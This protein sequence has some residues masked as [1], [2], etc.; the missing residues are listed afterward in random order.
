MRSFSAARLL[1]ISLLLLALPPLS[2]ACG[3]SFYRAAP[4]LRADGMTFAVKTLADLYDPPAAAIP[5]SENAARSASLQAAALEAMKLPAAGGRARLDAL[6]AQARREAFPSGTLNLLWDFRDLLDSTPEDS[7]ERET[8]INWRL[9]HT[10]ANAI[11]TLQR[12]IALNR[13]NLWRTQAQ[14]MEEARKKRQ[15]A[16]RSEVQNLSAAGAATALPALQPHWRMQVAAVWFRA[17]E[18]TR[19]AYEFESIVRDFPKHPRVETAAFMALRCRIELARDAIGEWPQRDDPRAQ[20][21]ALPVAWDNLNHFAE[22]YGQGRFAADLPGWKG[23]LNQIEGNWPQAFLNYIEQAEHREQPAA[24][25]SGLREA[26]RCLLLLTKNPRSDSGIDRPDFSALAE[27]PQAAMRLI[28]FLL[29]PTATTRFDEWPWSTDSNDAV[30]IG[31][32]QR[33][34]RWR[35]RQDCE[36]WLPEL[37]RI[38]ELKEKSNAAGW[39]PFALAVVAW[40]ACEEGEY[41]RVLTLCRHHED[42][43]RTGDDLRMVRA[44]ALQR[45]GR[46]AEA[47]AAWGELVRDFPESPLCAQATQRLTACL[48]E[49]GNPAAA[50]VTILEAQELERE[51]MKAAGAWSEGFHEYPLFPTGENL[52][53]WADVL[54]VAAPVEALTAAHQ[55]CPSGPVR[56]RLRQVITCRLLARGDFGAARNFMQD[57]WP[58]GDPQNT[59]SSEDADR[60]RPWPLPHDGETWDR[61]FAPVA[62]LLKTAREAAPESAGSAAAWLAAGEAVAGL[63]EQWSLSTV[64]GAGMNSENR[65]TESR[66]RLNARTLGYRAE[67]I[68][69]ELLCQDF[70]HLASDCWK[71]AE[72]A[73]PG[74]PA[75]IRAMGLRNEALRQRAEYTPFAARVADEQDWTTESARLTAALRDF[76]EAGAGLVST[77]AAAVPWQFQDFPWLRGNITPSQAGYEVLSCFE[78]PAVAQEGQGF[79]FPDPAVSALEAFGQKGRD[80]ALAVL[81]DLR[82]A[83]RSRGPGSNWESDRITLL[84][85]TG[86]VEAGFRSLGQGMS[87]EQ[88][89]EYL[90]WLNNPGFSGRTEFP[91]WQ[92]LA[93]Y[94]RTREECR[95]LLEEAPER[96]AEVPALWQLWMARHPGPGSAR[97]EAAAFQFTR[98]ECR[99]YRGW[100]R[101]ENADWPEGALTGSQYLVMRVDRS[102][103]PDPAAVKAVLEAFD[104]QWPQ[105]RFHADV[106]LLRAGAAMD[107]QDW[108][109]A[110]DQALPVLADPDHLE[111][112]MDAANL[113]ADLFLQILK[114]ECRPAL[115]SAIRARPAALTMLEK[116]MRSNTPGSRLLPFRDWLGVKRL[117][118]VP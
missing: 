9:E 67:D 59:G 58:A 98:A 65:E 57:P 20:D 60:R 105:S 104:H 87:R 72:A 83:I 42:L 66:I 93:D 96:S 14:E 44:I 118:P 91:G 110:L 2:P 79:Q 21:P 68:S 69:E 95:A 52:G 13:G 3:P 16:V 24:V 85:R 30:D 41:E 23:A 10:A 46:P 26:E 1:P 32:F 115:A 55:A 100:T 71:R 78:N 31:K 89:E 37:A 102:A 12:P 25:R 6:I 84:I 39:D 86:D 51:Q 35:I 73:D 40:A 36:G 114:P 34:T 8:Y 82:K 77:V 63:R 109:L 75:A 70:L 64:S 17:E 15:A 62:V 92:D 28:Y 4:P 99:R 19:A 113:V 111:L 5:E 80:A 106:A 88:L 49:S 53:Q 33:G 90:D 38:L 97:G 27:H 29:E 112:H 43:L 11:R 48:K 94:I 18:F 81:A 74:S 56:E 107:R 103:E 47:V 76:P 61:S 7:P 117:G 50:L 54:S 116:F 22:K 45:M 101:F 108:G